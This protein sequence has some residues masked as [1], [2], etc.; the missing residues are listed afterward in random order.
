MRNNLRQLLL[1]LLPLLLLV[2][3]SVRAQ[4]VLQQE[5]FESTPGAAGSFINLAGTR[6]YPIATT[7]S[8]VEYFVRTQNSTVTT[9]APGFFPTTG[10]NGGTKDGTFYVVGES[11]KGATTVSRQPGVITLNSVSIAGYASLKVVVALAS[12]R[13][14]A[15]GRMEQDDSL[16]IQVRFNG[17]GAWTT[18]GQFLGDNTTS[19]DPN[20]QGLWRQDV[21]LNNS[22]LDDVAA[23][24]PVM[25]AN[26]ADFTFPV[27]G[28]G[29]TMQTRILVGQYGGSEEF[30]IDNIRVTG[31]VSS[32]QA[33][34]LANIESTALPYAEGAPAA[35]ITSTLTVSDADNTTLTGGTVRFTAGFDNTEDQLLFVNQNG[36]SGSYN[37]GTG[38]L[39]L[40]GT[41]TLATYQAALR[42]VRYQDTDAIDATNGTRTVAFQ[43][44]DGITSSLS[45]SRDIAVTAAL[46]AAS[47]LPYTEDLTTDGEGTRYNSSHFTDL[48]HAAFFRTNVATSANGTFFEAGFAAPTF[49]NISNSYYWYGAGP[50]I[51]GP[52]AFFITKQVDAASYANLQFQVRLGAATGS[53]D[54]NDFVKLYYRLNNGT[55]VIFASFRSTDQTSATNAGT[56]N[57]AQDANP[58]NL[59]SPPTG[60]ALTPA[61]QNFTYALPAALNGQQVDFKI[62]EA[63]QDAN[64]N[65]ETIAFDLI[66]VTGTLL[67]PATVT[68]A[69]ATSVTT[70][71]AV[72]GG[73]VTADGGAAV[74][75]RGVVYSTT[76]TTPT[77]ADTKAA[78]GTGTGTFSATISPLTPGNTY[79]VR[80][81]ATNSV[82]TSYGAVVSFTTTP[83]APVV[84]V[85]ANGSLVNTT[86]PTYAG[87]AVAG[88]TVTV[89]VD[90]S[91]IGTATATAGGNW[92]L[93]Q[94]TALSQGSHTVRATAQTS[95][96]AVS[97]N[98]NTNTFTVDTVQ[99][100][101]AITSSTAANG[102][103]TTTSPI[104]Y[105]VTFSEAVTGFVAGDVTVTN[106]GISGFSGS[107]TTYTFNV[108][109]AANGAVTVSVPANVAQ[110]GAGNGNTAAT[111]NPYSITYSQPSATVSSVTRLTPSPTATAQVSYRVVFSASVTGVTVS[112]F[113]TT[114]TGT[115]TGT[116]VSSV[117]GTGTTY[118][119]TVNTGTGDGTLRLNVN[120]STG[121]TPSVSNV[122]Y[123]SG[124]VYAITKSFAAAP[125]LTIVGTGGTGSD[126]TAFVDTV[127]VLSG[128]SPFS[129]AL[130]N[131]SFEYHNAL[132]NG[133]F[134]Y[135]PTGASWTFNSQSGIAE[136]GSAFSP[137]TPIPNGI[138]VAF[139]QSNGSG[140]GQL[141][142]NLA[143]P[144]GS[145]YQVRFQAAQRVC[146][147]TLDQS[148]NV[149]L[150]GVYLGNILP[151]SSAYSTFTSATFA[152]TA[153]A[154]TAAITSTTAANG[155][156]SG[157]SPIAYTVTFSQSVGTSFTASDV[158]VGNGTV[159][160]F[161]PVSGTTYTFN[162]TPAANG[163]VTVDVPAN[164][165]NDANN[166]GNTAATQYSITYT[167]PVTAAPV[168]TTPGNASLVNTTTPTYTGTAVAGSTVTVF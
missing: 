10:T 103:S 125:S 6:F 162:V 7:G 31:V 59:S 29:S 143:V 34:V 128:G 145:S 87:T 141:Q 53:W 2:S 35:Q 96:S 119:V 56:G 48:S 112:N 27:S 22:S 64:R 24:S 118:T 52:T 30:A 164:V 135:N 72:L 148:L 28:S 11:V 46:D 88:S 74:T 82:G 127:R 4:T 151:N 130:R 102:G 80:A 83:N 98:S 54:S 100:T 14:T 107:G 157:T 68:T 58:T 138:A 95:G 5:S 49:T 71:S 101:V 39:T 61:L 122:P 99:P 57:L 153:P 47:T 79:Y 94:P 86:T 149:F 116:S 51:N 17:A 26:L 121:I 65:G 123:T 42:S 159:S 18:V 142:Q 37:T 168:L 126:V 9:D 134:G 73:N 137:I 67:A 115:V 90:G 8:N 161:T 12:T 13:G 147:T 20:G 55:W 38:I 16:R 19:P 154:L 91:A 105:T 97:A 165:A 66:Q 85:P 44:T 62:E 45:V 84:I 108:T 167:Q 146:C 152:V 40:T 117:S 109:P 63:G 120:N 33:P 60:T 50:N 136:S 140:N 76:N 78:N 32:N 163:L 113:N 21:N 81:Y 3:W 144:T 160:G 114:N 150:N 155:G 43:V 93:S 131:G 36:I 132:I 69:A 23:G 139:V 1:P 110:D 77:T 166:T 111:P 156:T 25:D 129:N 158:T 89:F 106:G 75:E 104:A 124:E 92:S 70:T 15:V 41:A 133:D